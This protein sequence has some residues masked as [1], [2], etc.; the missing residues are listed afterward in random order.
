MAP[1]KFNF[2]TEVLPVVRQYAKRWFA[3]DADGETKVCDAISAAWEG[4]RAAPTAPPISLA[5]YAVRRVRSGR[6]FR[7]SARSIDGP[8]PRR[9]AKP[10]RQ[11]VQV[12]EF[13]RVGDDPA[14]IAAVNIDYAAWL[15][16][17]SERQAE[18]L[19]M[20]I[21]GWTTA[22]VAAAFGCTAGNVSQFRRRLVELWQAYTA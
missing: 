4:H 3:R 14:E 20:L 8:N 2:D 6:Q 21:A 11:V 10:Q 5:Y 22:E 7:Q 13:S 12:E 19:A 18:M 17:L 9:M 16:R 15:P 1:A